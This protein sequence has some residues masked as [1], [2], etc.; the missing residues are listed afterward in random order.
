VPLGASVAQVNLKKS[1]DIT[2]TTT[3]GGCS[4]LNVAGTT[5][6]AGAAATGNCTVLETKGCT[7]PPRP[8]QH[9]TLTYTGP[10]GKPIY[11][12]VVTDKDGCYQDFVVN[13]QGGPW[14]VDTEYQGDVCTARTDGPTRQVFV[15][16]AGFGGVPVGGRGMWYS[17]HLGLDVPLGS[18]RQLYD[19]G[20]SA[21]IDAEYT[22]TDNVSLVAMLG[23][24][25]FAQDPDTFYYTN[26]SL[27]AK[28]YFPI[29]SGTS[30]FVQAGPGIYWPKSG[31]SE[32]G[33]NV[34]AG[35][36]FAVLPNLK[37]EVG[38][39]VHWVNTSGAKFYFVDTKLGVIFR[40]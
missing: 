18:S 5:S 17:F 7:V 12:D 28:R 38:P 14:S 6:L 15:P 19:P 39:D 1:T 29:T 11:H 22:L 4:K 3:Y 36:S 20:P 16:P 26:F 10:D 40:F 30:F 37:I 2:S 13:P 31:S 33:V 9:I 23:L 8:F 25:V 21:T 34:G 35:F 27:D 32:F 24:H